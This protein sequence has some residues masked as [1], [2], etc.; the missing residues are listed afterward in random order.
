MPTRKGRNILKGIRSRDS[1][2]FLPYQGE[3]SKK[4][5]TGGKRS[6]NSISPEKTKKKGQRPSEWFVFEY[7]IREG[8]VREKLHRRKGLPY[9]SSG[10]RPKREDNRGKEVSGWY[11][12]VRT[13]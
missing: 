4:G 13:A 2:G 12:S 9:S 5:G 11:V 1:L 8:N 6:S 3:G 7:K 10:T